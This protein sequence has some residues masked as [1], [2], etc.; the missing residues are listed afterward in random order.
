MYVATLDRLKLNIDCRV[1]WVNLFKVKSD[2]K[3]GF[4]YLFVDLFMIKF[5]VR[6]FVVHT[7]IDLKVGNNS[8][9]IG[10]RKI[11]R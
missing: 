6:F 3:S 9:N 11:T 2:L 5:A 8:A 1:F 7:E 4:K 10:N